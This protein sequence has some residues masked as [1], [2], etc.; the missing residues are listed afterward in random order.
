MLR[1]K[2][3]PQFSTSCTQCLIDQF[4][5]KRGTYRIPIL[6]ADEEKEK[7]SYLDTPVPEDAGLPVPL[8]PQKLGYRQNLASRLLQLPPE[9]LIHTMLFLPYSSLYM[10]CQTCQVLRN[11]TDDSQFEYFQWEILQHENRA[12][13]TTIPVCDQLRNI[14]RIFLRRSLCMPYGK[15]FGSSELEERLKKLWQPVRCTGCKTQ[16]PELLFPQGGRANNICVGLLG[17]FA[18]CNH[19]KIS[20]KVKST[21]PRTERTLKNYEPSNGIAHVS[22][23][24]AAV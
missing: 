11:L 17:E 3:G 18:L 14:K 8:K 2:P 6:E 12:S 19:I 10:V 1:F 22:I 21:F 15:L 5:F 24:C 7:V 16:H 13:Y 20:G 23:S 9:L 4:C